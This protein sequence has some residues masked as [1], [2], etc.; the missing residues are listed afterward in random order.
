MRVS[1]K[2]EGFK[3]IENALIELKTATA[4]NI[5]KKVLIKAGKP[6]ADAAIA[7]A[8]DDPATNGYD[9]KRS[10]A[11]SSKL[12]RR[13]KKMAR[14]TV[15]SGV[16]VY[17]GAGPLPQA[18][19]QEFGTVSHP[20]HPFMRPAW[21]ANNGKAFNSIKADMWTEIE[22]AANRA[23]RKAAKLAKK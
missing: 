12:S 17:V 14:R 8:P 7:Y 2:V 19:L 13:Q 11:V 20:A 16:E 18:H 21:D 15:K 4:K 1:F 10:I 6:I 3:D 5:A 9:L 23:A 22:A